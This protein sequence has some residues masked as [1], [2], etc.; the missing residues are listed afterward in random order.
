[1]A[2]GLGSMGWVYRRWHTGEA[3]T[4]AAVTMVQKQL[5]QPPRGVACCQC[6]GHTM[7]TGSV[8]GQWVHECERWVRGRRVTFCCFLLTFFPAP[9]VTL[10]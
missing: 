3:R 10:L 8:G 9:L 7:A 1:M 5:Q 4:D 2:A 6:D